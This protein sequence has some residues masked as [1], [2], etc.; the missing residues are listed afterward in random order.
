MQWRTLIVHAPCF[1]R[2]MRPHGVRRIPLRATCLNP[3]SGW[4]CDN[5]TILPYVVAWLAFCHAPV[6]MVY[7]LFAASSALRVT[8]GVLDD[9]SWGVA[10]TKWGFFNAIN[11]AHESPR[12]STVAA[13]LGGTLA[14]CGGGLTQQA[15]SLLRAE[16]AFRTPDSLRAPL[17]SMGGFGVKASFCCVSLCY[18]LLDPHGCVRSCVPMA[19]L[20]AASSFPLSNEDVVYTAIVVMCCVST[21]RATI[22]KAIA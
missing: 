7:R 1:A 11:A 20:P 6:D 12:G 10:L 19:L 9:I 8:M 4:L 21:I 15:C 2:V 16:W 13:V 3:D 5:Q 14:G 17:L 18:A 22:E